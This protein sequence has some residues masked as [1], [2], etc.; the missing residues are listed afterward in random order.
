MLLDPNSA[1]LA[2]RSPAPP[3]RWHPCPKAPLPAAEPGVVLTNAGVNVT[4]HAK[5]MS[6]AGDDRLEQ[7]ANMLRRLLWKWGHRHR[8]GRYATSVWQIVEALA[9]AMGWGPVPPK[10]HPDR[11]RWLRA[12]ARNVRFWLEHLQG[13]GIISFEHEPD[14]R[15]QHWRTIITLH[16]A[17][18]PPAD[19][20]A[21]A[22]RRHKAFKARRRI[23]ARRRRAHPERRRRGRL[24]ELIRRDCA[25]PQ[26][27][28]RRRLAIA[29]ACA[30]KD[31]QA[32][33]VAA[34]AAALDPSPLLTK[35]R[36]HRFTAPPAEEPIR[37]ENASAT[38]HV[39]WDRSG[40]THAHATELDDVVA[41]LES[42]PETAS[43]RKPERAGEPDVGELQGALLWQMT[44]DELQA[45]V[46][47][48]E[49]ARRARVELVTSHAQR[50][51]REVAASSADRG[52]PP[53][54]LKEAWVVWR[55]GAEVAGEHGPGQA[56]PLQPGDLKLLAGAVRRYEAHA[57][58]RPPGWPSGGYAALEQIATRARDRDALPVILHWAIAELEQLSVRMHAIAV[59][60][61]PDRLA[62]MIARAHRRRQPPAPTR[63]RFRTPSSA[64][65]P[66]AALDEHGTPIL[67]DDGALV[68]LDV[69][70]APQRSEERYRTVLRDAYL[71]AG[72]WPPPE[73]DG[74]TARAL[75]AGAYDVEL[76]E[77][78]VLPGPYPPP[79][80]ARADADPADV[81]LARLTAIALRT[82][83]RL[84][85]AER[86]RRLAAARRARAEH[87]RDEHQALARRLATG[88][89]DGAARP[90]RPHN[91]P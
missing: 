30:L 68:L 39:C 55:H 66:W 73:A 18:D 11:Q 35:H 34:A 56:G 65:P 84:A 60:D 74:P 53:W 79:A 15:G 28:T 7:R 75:N 83:Q 24:L 91:A 17:P 82:V 41:A 42:S 90:A 26:A 89:H 77:R 3:R 88:P 76:G 23:Q 16:K 36:A 20:L 10:G 72:L 5:G 4:R 64:W 31:H 52:W 45:H 29:R 57:A 37:S 48:L 22:Q 85:V 27:A 87:T 86:G 32:A 12:H 61:D 38:S 81:E 14:N 51:A 59:A 44:P 40:V 71:V 46:A 21:A 2:P 80:G 47:E 54:R 67:T 70:G 13:A 8:S 19:E 25:R 58:R 49:A 43:P 78:R 9:P 6:T 62:R 1:S 69:L 50:R 33:T 63:L